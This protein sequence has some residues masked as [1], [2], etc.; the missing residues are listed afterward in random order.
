[1][2][3][4]ERHPEDAP[5]GGALVVVD[6]REAQR[7]HG[8][9][10]AGADRR[11]GERRDLATRPADLRADDVV[12]DLRDGQARVEVLRD[13]EVVAARRWFL[14]V[15][16]AA[17]NG[18]DLI[19]TRLVLEAGGEEGNPLMAPIIHHPYAP[20]LVKGAGLGLVALVLRSCPRSAIVDRALCGVTVLYLAIVT[21][22]LTNLAVN[23]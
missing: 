20:V 1:M 4:E 15:V 12:I 10:A 19:S 16:L 6:R 8:P 14:L 11:Q 5:H 2:A 22:N 3:S 17:L 9:R 21:W 13:L 23:G 7:R 18:L